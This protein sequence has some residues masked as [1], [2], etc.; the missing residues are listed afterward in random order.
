[1]PATTP[2]EDARDAELNTPSADRDASPPTSI[3]AG[4]ARRMPD[5]SALESPRV[6]SP[7]CVDMEELDQTVDAYSV[8]LGVDV[9]ARLPMP[10]FGVTVVSVG[11]LAI[12]GETREVGDSASVARV[13]LVSELDAAATRIAAAGREIATAPVAIPAGR[14]DVCEGTGRVAQRVARVTSSVG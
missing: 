3:P 1:M 2:P 6:F 12:V 11:G 5:S 7:I 14:L 13:I 8:A 4:R 10:E 9:D